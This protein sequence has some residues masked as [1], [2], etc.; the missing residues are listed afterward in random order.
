VFKVQN[1]IFRQMAMK[2]KRHPAMQL[3]IN[4]EILT[5]PACYALRLFSG[6]LGICSLD[7]LDLEVYC[8]VALC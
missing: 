3:F 8:V 1:S 6:G 2:N 7:H 4:L 5:L